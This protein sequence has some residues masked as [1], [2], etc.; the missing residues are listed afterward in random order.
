M[1]KVVS[2]SIISV[3]ILL[4]IAAG[5]FYYQYYKS[6]KSSSLEAVPADVAWLLRCNP[7][8]GELRQIATSGFFAAKDSVPL[9]KEW[10]QELLY[11]DSLSV[12]TKEL[13]QLFSASP[14]IIT[15]HVTGPQS[16]SLLFI[17]S[18][19]NANPDAVA[20][21]VLKQI[22]Y[23]NATTTL[24]NY[25]GVD[26]REV[27]LGHDKRLFSWAV[28]RGVFIGSFTSYL[29]E[30][31][32]RQ[33][34]SSGSTSP[35]VRLNQFSEGEGS[36]MLVAIRYSGFAKWV[37]TQL[38]L[39]SGV[40][41]LPLERLGDWSIMQLTVHPSLINF[42]GITT[43]EDSLEFLSLFKSEDPVELKVTRIM[44]LR[45]AGTVVWGISNP[46]NWLNNLDVYLSRSQPASPESQL[47]RHTLIPYFQPWLGNELA[48][49]ITQ[50]VS[51]GLENHCFA[52]IGI[53]D[54]NSCKSSL[55]KLGETVKNTSS[56][57][58]E[59][60]NGYTIRY[61]P[62]QGVLPAVLGPLF[63]RVN[64][65]YYTIIEDYLVVANQASALRGYINDV[66]T[67]NL[68]RSN[69]R[70]N[71]LLQQTPKKIN[72]FFY[73]NIPQSEKIFRSVAAPHWVNWLAQY[74]NT[75]KGWNGLT[76]SVTTDNGIFNT[77]GCI[78]YYHEGTKGPHL[79]WNS[80]LDAD[81]SC[82]PFIPSEKN[83]LILVSDQNQQL[84]AFDVE[85]TVKWKKKLDSPIKG[86]IYAVDYLKNGSDQ[87][88]FNTHSFIYILDSSGNNVGNFPIR[89]PAEASNGIAVI[90]PDSL[91]SPKLYIA[92]TN[93][94]IYGYELTGKP[95][96]GFG[97]L[98]V[99]DLVYETI[100]S[101]GKGENMVLMVCD[102][103][104]LCFYAD[105]KGDRYLTVK[106]TIHK[107]QGTAFLPLAKNQG[108]ITWLDE[109]NSVYT[110]DS[111]GV[112][113]T[114]L[115]MDGD[116]ITGITRLD[117]NGDDET[118][119]II[120]RSEGVEARTTD[121]VVLFHYKVE[122]KL[123]SEPSIL[124]S[125]GKNFISF[126]DGDQVYLLNRD[127]SLYDGFPQSGVGIPVFIPERSGMNFTLVVKGDQKS[128]SLI[129]VD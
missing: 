122:N 80:K 16:F 66:K 70:F 78:S 93:L 45:T 89:L 105:R 83:N 61:I 74:S 98:K 96:T 116:T 2:S 95:L 57:A 65:F 8:M 47:N 111:N 59:S 48:L 125:K 40:R 69:E 49:M 118:D 63:V 23:S 103:N 58:E 75:L 68:L 46:K 101:T 29:V 27:P 123:C 81:I 121:G 34:R 30:D 11:F 37:K 28:S 54:M 90:Q 10:Q 82:G 13:K 99:P 19:H 14:L 100:Q 33:Q 94:R 32:I 52:I 84:S 120:T 31:A 112:V 64:R 119:W 77:A 6:G 115:K 72:L 43:V 35:A 41:L 50:P 91:Q 73:A 3:V 22:A 26:I 25:N 107:K 9:L 51:S 15:G 1:K 12:N 114:L 20:S 24:R 42:K 108:L 87:Y 109:D 76:F 79:A 113:T 17:T 5:F 7:S 104:G 38:D 126:N 85:G 129:Q 127:G 124:Q 4:A 44:P 67:G 88:L 62:L 106:S 97:V 71:I 18:I 21:K 92:C 117:I 60:Y 102:R 39:A 86:K 110:A 55:L 36:S 53:N 128:I 56:N